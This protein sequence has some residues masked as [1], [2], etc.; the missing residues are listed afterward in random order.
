MVGLLATEKRETKLTHELLGADPKSY[1]CQ[2]FKAGQCTK[3]EKCKYSH[4]LG[5][6][7]KS[8]KIDLYSDARDT[9][10]TDTMDTWDQDKLE[11]VVLKKHGPGIKTTTEIVCKHFLDAIEQRKY[12]WFWE[13]PGGGDACKYRHALPPGYVFKQKASKDDAEAEDEEQGISLEEF[14]EGERRNLKGELTPITAESFAIWKA[15]RLL[16]LKEETLNKDKKKQE[17]VKAGKTLATGREMFMVNPEM[18]LMHDD[19]GAF[20]DDLL[21][22]RNEDF[23]VDAEGITTAPDLLDEERLLAEELERLQAQ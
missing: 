16:R 9:K 19:E 6:E 11:S 2:A 1:L 23:F 7:R 14:L 3:G 22:E 5:V 20:E 4:D 8:A 15:A 18:F 10:D 21:K 13:C 12:G 17:D